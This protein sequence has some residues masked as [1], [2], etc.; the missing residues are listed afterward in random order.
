MDAP[1]IRGRV[2]AVFTVLTELYSNA[3]EHG[4]LEL[5][6]SMKKT[7]SGFTEYYELREEKIRQL[8]AGF[9]RFDVDYTGD[10]NQGCLL[11]RVTDSGNG[12]DFKSVSNAEA[13][14]NQS[15]KGRG[16]L[17]IRNLCDQLRFLDSGNI[18]EVEFH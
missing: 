12:F 10:E 5:D 4:I 13:K 17:I 1:S 18:V 2:G 16:L 8:Q 11:I 15:F 3:L 6:S 7:P 14:A 9:I